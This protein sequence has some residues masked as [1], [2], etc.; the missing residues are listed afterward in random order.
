VAGFGCDERTVAAWEHRAGDHSQAVHAAVVQQGQ[1]DLQHVQA[2][3]LWVKLVGRRLW[4]AM[5]I[6]VPSRLWLGGV[7]S[8][9]RDRALL[10]RLVAC[11]RACAVS[12]A[13]LVCVD[14]LAGYVAAFRNGF[15]TPEP[16]GLPGRPKLRPEPGLQIGQVIKQY[17]KRRVVSS[18]TRVVQGTPEQ[19]EAVL[20]HSGGGKQINTAFIERLNA[21]WRSRLAALVRRGRALA[22][23]D[24][25]LMSS[26]YLVGGLYNFCTPH[27]SLR[28][29]APA[30]GG[31]QWQERTPAMAAG[32]TDH[33]WSVSEWL[34]HRIPP[35]PWEPP[36][37]PGRKPKAPRVWRWALRPHR[38]VY[39]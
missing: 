10:A 15:R 36:K 34:Q 14:G 22:R 27:A 30:G 32:L 13:L 16:T 12:L 21:T 35:P 31:R 29:L 25:S 8:Q 18:M 6:A 11:V 39:L 24:A 28:E 9:S 37:R 2:D 17:R 38:V 4:L 3:E 26:L 7:V 33:A 5:A 20:A 23:Q 19:I 1:V